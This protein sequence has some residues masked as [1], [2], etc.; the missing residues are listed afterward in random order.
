MPH[1]PRTHGRQIE[2][3][4]IKHRQQEMSLLLSSGWLTLLLHVS[5]SPNPLCRSSLLAAILPT[6]RP[7]QNYFMHIGN[8]PYPYTGLHYNNNNNDHIQGTPDPIPIHNLISII[9]HLIV[10]IKYLHHAHWTDLASINVKLC[11]AHQCQQRTTTTDTE[12]DC[13]SGQSTS[14]PAS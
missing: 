4:K 10:W 2:K 3:C 5:P 12:A 6:S 9:M 1:G 8:F 14:R 7:V 11:V 13:E